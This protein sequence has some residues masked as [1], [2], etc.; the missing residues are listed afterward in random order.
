MEIGLHN[1]EEIG[2]RVTE[3]SRLSLL[4]V[5]SLGKGTGELGFRRCYMIRFPMC[6][7]NCSTLTPG[8]HFSISQE[9]GTIMYFCAPT[10]AA[11]SE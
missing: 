8:K 3:N 11:E 7:K 6:W 5:A 2:I 10:S 9:K 4:D 1:L